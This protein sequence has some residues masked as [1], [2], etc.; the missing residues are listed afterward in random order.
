M[1]VDA[2][3]PPQAT[4]RQVAADAG[5][6]KTSVS[7]YFGGERERLSVG[8]QQRIQASAER[9]GYRPNQ[10]A[11]G[12]KGGHSRLIGM[13]MADIRNP[14]SIDVMH[15]AEQACREHG[16]SLVVCN[17]DNDPAQEREHLAL[18]TSYRVEGLIINAAGHPS[19]ELSA[20]ADRGTPLVLLDRTL[21]DYD[22]DV[23][24]LDNRQAID[25]ALNH[26]QTQGYRHLLY[27]SEPPS[28]ASSRQTRLERFHQQLETHQ[29]SGTTV[30]LD[31]IDETQRLDNAI[32]DFLAD[33]THSDSPKA[34]L[35]GNGNITLAVARTLVRHGVELGNVGLMGIDELPWAELVGPGITTL[36]Q[37]TDLIGRAAIDTLLQRREDKDGT[38]P[39]RHILYHGRLNARGSTQRHER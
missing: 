4:I 29:L 37:P 1:T 7:R 25:A 10:M 15:G 34:I 16:L 13:V 21:S 32:D 38:L 30:T 31:L 3:I 18:L 33:A 28:Q 19:R 35:C 26:L 22:A 6:S 9:L 39:S 2:S 14:F 17:T 12:L 23:V 36:A 24:A 20:L 5:V 11:R 8:M 27:V